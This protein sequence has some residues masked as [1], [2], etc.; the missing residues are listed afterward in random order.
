MISK[1]S[2][3][4]ESQR[5]VAQVIKF[6]AAHLPPLEDFHSLDVWREQRERTLDCK[7]TDDRANGKAR[8]HPSILLT[9]ADSRE[10]LRSPSIFWNLQRELNDV[11]RS[12][13]NNLAL[14][15]Q[16]LHVLSFQGFHDVPAPFKVRFTFL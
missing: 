7:I 6:C 16:R 10:Y 15:A 12:K 2:R 5:F 13:R 11:P 1:N 4:R 14:F 9:D 8:S 3:S